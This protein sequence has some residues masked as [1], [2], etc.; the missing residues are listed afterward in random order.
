MAA[1]LRW[2]SSMRKVV[3]QRM[4]TP[5]CPLI[6]AVCPQNNDPAR[7]NYCPAW[8]ESLVTNVMTGEERVN[9]SCGWQQ[10]PVF[11][12]EVVKASNRPAAAIESTRNEIAAGM[13][14]V[15]NGLGRLADVGI[16]GLPKY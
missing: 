11:L 8:W 14:R 7:G 10:L 13:E 4:N 9:K 3:D 15:A 6:N 5:R 2:G 16:R 12:I 1:G